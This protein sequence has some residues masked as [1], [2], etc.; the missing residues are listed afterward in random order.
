MASIASALSRIKQLPLQSLNQHHVEQLCRQMGHQWRDREL[1]PAT[2]LAL[3]IQQVIHGNTPCSEVRHIAGRSFTASAYC[4]AR[5]RLPLGVCQA[6]LTAVIDKALPLIDRQEH[7]WHGQRTFHID[8][9]TFSMPDT[10]Q[11][12]RVLGTPANQSGGCGFP[13]AHLLVLF[14][15][16]TGILLDVGPS[17]TI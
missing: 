9:S 14:S 1:D 5:A 16:T 13:T 8:G 12:R 3:F 2:T 17:S 10:P 6:M 15:A 11:L 4:Q 7:R